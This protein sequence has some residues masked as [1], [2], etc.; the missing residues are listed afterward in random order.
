M[1]RF[2]WSRAS[3]PLG[4]VSDSWTD[5]PGHNVIIL[6]FIHYN[7]RDGGGLVRSSSLGQ[8]HYK[9]LKDVQT[10]MYACSVLLVKN[11]SE[12]NPGEQAGL[13]NEC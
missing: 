3:R 13:E 10:A 11:S 1:L 12:R 7:Y 9:V 8:L 5:I 6:A 4:N 2:I